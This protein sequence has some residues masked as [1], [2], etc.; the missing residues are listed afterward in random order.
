MAD[1]AEPI[2]A[3]VAV[4]ATSLAHPDLARAAERAAVH[5]PAQLGSA[6]AALPGRVHRSGPKNIIGSLKRDRNISKVS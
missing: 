5:D 1:G 2:G 6:S 4:L 3:A